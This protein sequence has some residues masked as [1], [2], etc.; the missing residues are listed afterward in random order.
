[1]PAFLCGETSISGGGSLARGIYRYAFR[2]FA[3]AFLFRAALVAVLANPWL[4]HGFEE[5]S[6]GGDSSAYTSTE[7]RE[8]PAP[9]AARNITSYI[10]TF[11]PSCVFFV[12]PLSLIEARVAVA[13]SPRNADFLVSLALKKILTR[14]HRYR[15]PPS[16]ASRCA[17]IR[18]SKGS[19]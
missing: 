17:C 12:L 14:E 7:S 6:R 9:F 18:E 8:S 16:P 5:R 4:I 1:M 3:R 10:V 19:F 11:N 15:P 13:F 2:L